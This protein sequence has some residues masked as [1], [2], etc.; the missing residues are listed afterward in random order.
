MAGQKP[1]PSARARAEAKHRGRQEAAPAREP[2]ARCGRPTVSTV[3][4][5]RPR[6][7]ALSAPSPPAVQRGVCPRYRT[8]GLRLLQSLYSTGSEKGAG[9]CQ[10]WRLLQAGP[11]VDLGC[12]SH[13]VGSSELVPAERLQPMTEPAGLPLLCEAASGSCTCF[14]PKPQRDEYCLPSSN[15]TVYNSHVLSPVMVS[16][17]VERIP[18]LRMSRRKRLAAPPH[19]FNSRRS[20][21]G[22][23]PKRH[24]LHLCV[25]LFTVLLSGACTGS[26]QRER[27]KIGK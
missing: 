3:R 26:R 7:T 20:L 19:Q 6:V 18:C 8:R 16:P 23:E 1:W 13:S 15:T 11:E 14:N 17:K 21:L 2:R 9:K 25:S 27:E 12:I 5:A 4:K 10:N 22:L 24:A